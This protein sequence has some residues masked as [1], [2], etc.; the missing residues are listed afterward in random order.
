MVIPE[1]LVGLIISD[2]EAVFLRDLFANHSHFQ[3]LMAI[4]DTMAV[5]FEEL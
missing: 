1:T 4:H 3:P 5:L 2:P